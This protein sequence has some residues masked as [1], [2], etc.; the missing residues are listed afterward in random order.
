MNAGTVEETVDTELD[1]KGKKIDLDNY[2]AVRGRLWD[3][4]TQDHTME[5]SDGVGLRRFRDA[6]D[7]LENYEKAQ[8]KDFPG[9]N[10]ADINLEFVHFRYEVPRIITSRILFP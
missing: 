4:K 10:N 6:A 5:I 1:A 8:Y 7:A 2:F 3:P 9:E